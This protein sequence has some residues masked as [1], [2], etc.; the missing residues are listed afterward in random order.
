MDEHVLREQEKQRVDSSAS[1]CD[2]VIVAAV[3][4]V[5]STPSAS[6]LPVTHH[7]YSYYSESSDLC[8]YQDKVVIH[9]VCVATDDDCW[10]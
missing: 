5:T 1:E 6:L 3:A 10:C 7:S 8:D 2:S 4:F 9:I